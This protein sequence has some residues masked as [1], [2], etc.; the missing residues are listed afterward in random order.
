MSKV[1]FSIDENQK[2][3]ASR[4]ERAR[5]GTEWEDS[6]AKR[7]SAWQAKRAAINHQKAQARNKTPMAER[8][9]MGQKLL[10]QEQAHADPIKVIK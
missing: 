1:G 4:S 2:E 6:L 8:E 5:G 3:G 9:A 7:H 10:K